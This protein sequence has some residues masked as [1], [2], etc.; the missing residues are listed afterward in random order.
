MAID[1]SRQVVERLSVSNDNDKYIK[2]VDEY[3]ALNHLADEITRC[4]PA[5]EVLRPVVYFHEQQKRAEELA[6]NEQYNNAVNLLQTGHIND[7][8]EAFKRLEW[9]KQQQPNY[10]GIDRQLAI[11]RDLATYKIVIEHLPELRRSHDIDS[12]IFYNRLYDFLIRSSGNDFTRFYKPALA[13]ELEITPHEIVTIQFHEF[14]INTMIEKENNR[15]YELDSAVVG[16]FIDAEGI[17]REVKGSVKA[18]ATIY[19]R[20]ILTRGVLDISITDFK[21]NEIIQTRKFPGEFIW[22]NEWANFNGDER[23]IPSDVLALTKNKQQNPPPPQEM[24]LLWSDPIYQN[25]S[26]YLRSYFN[27]RR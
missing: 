3:E 6:V 18:T 17:E 19:S 8:R 10:S 14:S 22:K 26:S 16:T 4:P 13:E 5:L 23:A 7:A 21:T 2:I 24:F 1:Y 11:A 20:E 12:R 27:R 9:V 25:S 15:T